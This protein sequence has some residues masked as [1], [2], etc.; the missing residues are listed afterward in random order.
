MTLNLKAIR[1]ALALVALCGLLY[2]E[3]ARAAESALAIRLDGALDDDAWKT[4]R[5]LEAFKTVEFKVL[6]A[7][8]PAGQKPQAQTT[9]RL[10]ADEKYLYL[11]F[12][13]EEPLMQKLE[14]RP[15]PRDGSIW[16]ND[17]IE[18]FIAPF[19]RS[20]EYFQITVDLNGQVFDAFKRAGELDRGYDLTV[21]SK[22]QKR[23]GEWTMELAIP[24]C[25]LGLSNLRAARMNF[26]RERKPVN[27]LTSWHGDFG[28]P[29]T[30]QTVPL[31]LEKPYNVEVRD[32]SFGAA[33][34]GENGLAVE[35]APATPAPVGVLLQTLENGRW[36]NKDRKI[37][38]SV[39]GQPTRFAMPYTLEPQQEPRG[40]RL[41][42]ERG[43]QPMFRVTR[44]LSLPAEALVATATLPYSYSE[45]NAAFLQLTSFVSASALQK[46][47]IRLTVKNPAGEIVATKEIRPL[48]QVMRAGFDISAWHTGA[49]TVVAELISGGKT[50]SRREV[51]VVKRP[52]PFT[53]RRL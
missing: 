17:C 4:A 18:V 48:Q 27:E 24:L 21:R 31:V 41:T 9:G 29:E 45:E 35:F 2:A 39:P 3:P 5:Q 44:R 19:A 33:Q 32:W 1:R 50:L 49:G 38:Q 11:G 47:R 53:S 10:F 36:T 42:L 46:S 37:A 15:L 20:D 7:V 28:K 30:W 22:A 40:I 25:E 51:E 14:A 34:Y 43:G 8:T 52:G 23:A 6:R 12:R 26:G 13:C 16:T